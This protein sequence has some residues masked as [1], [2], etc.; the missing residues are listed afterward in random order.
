MLEELLNWGARKD[1]VELSVPRRSFA[2]VI[3]P[4]RTRQSLYEALMQ[5]EKHG[6]IFQDWGLGERHSTATGPAFKAAGPHG[7]GKTICDEAVA[8]ALGRKLFKVRY[9]EM[10]S[11]W[12]GESGKNVVAVFR[13]ARQ[14]DAV[15][16][17]DEADSIAS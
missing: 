6:L 4:E 5:I 2:D 12:A 15:L 1:L 13:D 7:T 11:C 17:F 10:A 14:Q 8:R 16:F 9:S 3:L